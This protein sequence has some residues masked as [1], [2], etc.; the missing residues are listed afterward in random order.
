[1]LIMKLGGISSEKEAVNF[2]VSKVEDSHITRYENNL[3]PHPM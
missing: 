1:M 2:L 3:I